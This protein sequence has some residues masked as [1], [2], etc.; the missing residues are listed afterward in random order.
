[1]KRILIASTIVVGAVLSVSAQSDVVTQLGSSVEEAHDAIFS[2][3]SSGNVYMSG[4]RDVFKTA[5][6][7]TRA[8]LV[9]G[10]IN[11]A[12]AYT[13]TADFAKRWGVFRENRKPSPPQPGP[14]SMAAI[15]EQQKKG[16]EDAIKNM[17]ET[18]KKMPELK[19]TF[20]EQIKAMRLQLAELSKQDPA[21]NAQMDAILKQGAEQAQ[22]QHKLELAEWEKNYPVDPKPVI[23]KRLRDFLAVS[24]TVDYSA[25]LVAK[26]GKMRFENPDYERKDSQWKYMYRAGKPAVDAARALAQE[27]LKALG[28]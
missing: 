2:A 24:A 3:F 27:W 22:A 23:A 13:T 28:G 12:R 15:Q 16:F 14:T 8:L 4:T 10:V 20:D 1:M 5:N 6:D 17:E 19:A 7:Q 9:T 21:A 18:A 26:N 25:K 11:L